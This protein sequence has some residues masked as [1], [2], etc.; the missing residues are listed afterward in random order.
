[1]ATRLKCLVCVFGVNIIL[2]NPVT[3]LSKVYAQES[4]GFF[5]WS[6][7]TSKKAFYPGEPILLTLDI[8]NISKQEQEIYFGGDGIGAFSM[9]I[10]DSNR[11]VVAKGN[12]IQR[13]G[14]SGSV[15]TRVPTAKTV[16]KSIVLN[17][18]C[19]TLLPPGQYHVICNVDYR[20]FSEFEGDKGGPLHSVTLELDI[21]LVK[22]DKSKLKTILEN[23]ADQESKLSA[24]KPKTNDRYEI[25]EWLA[26][27][28][29][30]REMIA[31]TE[32]ELAVP[33][34]FRILKVA[35]STWL[36]V[37]LINS[38][39]WSE[40]L[41]AASGLVQIIEDPSIYMDDVK[42]EAIDAVYRLR[43]TGKSEI[44]KATDEF[45]AKYKRPVLSAP[46]D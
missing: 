11:T 39:A 1:M 10:L 43:E 16:N 2:G 28:R 19:S 13:S 6:I 34:Q 8:T 15:S 12:K 45:V 23:L 46:I 9:E 30:T 21:K 20:L 24:R 42:R 29:T 26:A 22:L 5:D 36:K 32:S 38:L 35:K 18:W 31:F 3:I 17:Q 7:E 27:Q 25:G 41:E 37:D 33:Y 40:T 14:F 4:E 44:I